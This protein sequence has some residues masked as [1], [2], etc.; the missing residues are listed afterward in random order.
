MMTILQLIENGSIS[1]DTKVLGELPMTADKAI[2]GHNAIIYY[3]EPDGNISKWKSELEFGECTK[4]ER[5][6]YTSCITWGG[7]QHDAEPV[8]SCYSSLEAIKSK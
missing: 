2:I 8:T 1:L 4:F 5:G 3:P 6:N 7:P